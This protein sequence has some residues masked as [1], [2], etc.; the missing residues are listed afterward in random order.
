MRFLAIA[1]DSFTILAEE[2]RVEK[3]MEWEIGVWEWGSL[4]KRLRE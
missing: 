2:E 4:K 3:L 1:K